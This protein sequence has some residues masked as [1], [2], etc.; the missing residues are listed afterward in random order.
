M[1]IRTQCDHLPKQNYPTDLRNGCAVFCKAKTEKWGIA[2]TIGVLALYGK[3]ATLIIVG[4]FA[5]RTNGT[6]NRANYRAILIVYT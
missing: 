2:Q 3:R 6:Y 1:I 5:G 4:W